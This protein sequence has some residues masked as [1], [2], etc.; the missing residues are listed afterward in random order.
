MLSIGALTLFL[1]AV[2]P[3][4]GNTPWILGGMAAVLAP[5]GPILA[6]H[7]IGDRS[8]RVPALRRLDSLI[9][10]GPAWAVATALLLHV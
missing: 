3:F 5:L 4:D 8:A 6:R 2:P 7:L 1:A 9:L 10:L